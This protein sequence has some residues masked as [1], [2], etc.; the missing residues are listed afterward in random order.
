MTSN[1]DLTEIRKQ[2][3]TLDIEIVRLIQDRAKL[4]ATI[5]EIKKSKGEPIYRPDR[6]KE[7][8]EKIKR[9]NQGPLSDSANVS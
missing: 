8:Y 3:D 1:Q 6:E 7:V 5:G 9:I 4:A 2:I